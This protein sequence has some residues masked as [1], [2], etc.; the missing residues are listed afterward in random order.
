MTDTP[1][2]SPPGSENAVASNFLN[3]LRDHLRGRAD[4]LE[5]WCSDRNI[6]PRELRARYHEW[7][8]LIEALI[9]RSFPP[10]LTDQWIEEILVE[11]ATES[12][13]EPDRRDPRDLHSADTTEEPAAID[14]YDIRG[15]IARG[16]MGRVLEVWDHDLDRQLAMKVIAVRE[17]DQRSVLLDRFLSEARI[18][19]QLDHPG[20]VPVHDVGVDD[21]GRVYFTMR[22]VHGREL[23]EVFTLAR[24]KREGWTLHRALELVIKTCDTAAFAHSKS[25]IHRDIKP[26][27]IMVG[28]FGEVYIMDWGLAKRLGD[29]TTEE[30]RDPVSRDSRSTPSLTRAGSVVGTPFYMAPEQASTAGGDVGP[31]ADIY[32]LGALLYSL[33][34]GEPP[35][36]EHESSQDVLN[37]LRA[38][39]P[40][41]LQTTPGKLRVPDALWSICVRAMSRRPGD[42]YA[43]A[44][45]LANALRDYLNASEA[46]AEEA[47]TARLE[48]DRSRRIADF[49][50]SLFEPADPFDDASPRDGQSLTAR[51]VLSRSARRLDRELSEETGLHARLS[52]TLGDIHRKL[53]LIDEAG[54]L[55]EAGLASLEAESSP[56]PLD[57][58]EARQALG[59]R[60]LVAG[61]YDEAESHLVPALAGF[62]SQLGPGHRKSIHCSGDLAEVRS[63]RGDYAGAETRYRDAI[64]RLGGLIGADHSEVAELRN[65]RGWA[66]QCLG[67]YSEARTE[68]T[69]ALAV[70]RERWG[71]RHPLVSQTLSNLAAATQAHGDLD[72]AAALYEEAIRIHEQ[73]LSEEHPEN[74]AYLN[75]LA[76]LELERGRVERSVEL[77]Q[78]AHSIYHRIHG[79]NHPEVAIASNNFGMALCSQGDIDAAA[80]LFADGLQLCERLLDEEH[81][82]RPTL[83][84]NLAMVTRLRG[85]PEAASVQL[86]EAVSRYE[87]RLVKPHPLLARC[88]HEIAQTEL[89]LGNPEAGLVA[90]E[91][92]IAMRGRLMTRPHPDVAATRSVMADIANELG[93]TEVAEK[94]A[95]DALSILDRAGIGD[96][97]ERA[98]AY[99]S[100]ARALSPTQEANALELYRDA[101]AIYRTTVKA[102]DFRLV[103]TQSALDALRARGAE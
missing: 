45:D 43:T 10:S 3:F 77:H 81:L 69:A 88:W 1:E 100:L 39:P 70:Q 36:A 13:G 46:A 15:E 33:M 19:S 92:A 38:G 17:P 79:G 4:D 23:G 87:P 35:Y 95:R 58:A 72:N 89:A 102:T 7:Q 68:H 62:E 25:I 6:P 63:S 61:R 5:A 83:M 37:A 91:K 47:R 86:R 90:A 97:L 41:G 98:H 14:R 2:A 12:N 31:S 67:R 48:A 51:D 53:G 94:H 64:E 78:R 103:R 82:L 11:P 42:R 26:D 73:V 18:T 30:S 93:Q 84:C 76:V 29:E 27:N 20:V 56:V 66:L 9:P 52:V 85:D 55:L 99:N 101:L 60:C 80:A 28:D 8:P 16:G 71:N 24:D 32:A 34:R 74:A 40:P 49:L 54:R 96:H 50:V 21:N 59:L 44:S 57:I 75:N 65:R 22:R